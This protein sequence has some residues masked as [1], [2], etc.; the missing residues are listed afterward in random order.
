MRMRRHHSRSAFW[1][2]LALVIP[3]AYLCHLAPHAHAETHHETPLHHHEEPGHHSH[4]HA[5][6]HGDV[7][8]A[9]D[10][11]QHHHSLGD[12]SDSHLFKGSMRIL[13][14]L[15]GLALPLATVKT[16]DGQ[17]PERQ[18]HPDFEGPPPLDRPGT[19]CAQRAPPACG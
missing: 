17:E 13:R 14:A 1:I 15:E 4:E 3:V 11:G 18:E 6:A 16:E 7:D 5:P 9:E 10:T 2:G 12:H 8:P 19:S